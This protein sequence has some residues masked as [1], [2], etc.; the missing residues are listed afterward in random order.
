MVGFFK[1]W[2]VSGITTDGARAS[3]PIHLLG[4]ALFDPGRF[5]QL[6][7]GQI[8]DLLAFGRQALALRSS[9][10]GYFL[11]GRKD[12]HDSAVRFIVFVAAVLQG[13]SGASWDWADVRKASQSMYSLMEDDPNSFRSEALPMINNIMEQVRELTEQPHR[14]SESS[15]SETTPTQTTS[16]SEVPWKRW[17][18]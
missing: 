10:D 3:L 4:S 15:T 6:P 1:S 8:A 18:Y 7:A 17:R 16:S 13:A 9:L 5:A 11:H 12:D 2:R 14:T